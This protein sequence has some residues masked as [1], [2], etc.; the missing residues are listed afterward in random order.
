MN[1]DEI[2]HSSLSEVPVSLTRSELRSRQRFL[3]TLVIIPDLACSVAVLC[4]P[5]QGMA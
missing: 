2:E 3:S 5:G 1:R 4:H